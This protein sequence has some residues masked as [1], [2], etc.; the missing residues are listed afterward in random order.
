[1][2]Y[3]PAGTPASETFALT[4]V[5]LHVE[6]KPSS[7]CSSY[8]STFPSKHFKHAWLQK[9]LNAATVEVSI[10]QTGLILE[11]V[12]EELMKKP[13]F[14]FILAST[15]LAGCV[16]ERPYRHEGPYGQERG[17]DRDHGPYEN[18]DHYD[19]D[20]PREE[21]RDADHGGY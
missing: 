7:S 13:M 5:V 3:D 21:H 19:R 18:R 6:N 4:V 17:Y 11:V 12:L 14:L 20:A 1:M 9:Q 16:Y 15:L 2:A 10:I 8:L